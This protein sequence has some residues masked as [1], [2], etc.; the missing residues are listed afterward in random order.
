MRDMAEMCAFRSCRIL[1]LRQNRLISLKRIAVQGILGGARFTADLV[2]R[3]LLY[4][5]QHGLER[6]DLR[7]DPC[8]YQLASNL[9]AID[10]IHDDH[11]IR[12][13]RGQILWP[14]YMMAGSRH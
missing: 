6:H 10:G 3:H 5:V 12:A 8:I 7:F 14:N 13:D 1:D 2:L 9:I 11:Q 4:P